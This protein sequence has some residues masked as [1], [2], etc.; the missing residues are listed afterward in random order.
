MK[1]IITKIDE[2]WIRANNPCQAA[3]DWWDKKEKDPIKILDAL[4]KANKLDWAN[5]YIVRIMEYAD[6][7]AYV[8]YAAALVLPDY[9]ARY[10]DDIRPRQA[11]EAARECIANPSEK[12]KTAAARAAYRVPVVYSAANSDTYRAVNSAAYST[13]YSATLK[14]ILT[15]GRTLLTETKTKE[16]KNV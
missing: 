1:S 15:Y 9:E 6:Y 14:T 2:A 16:V 3:L 4:I 10:P 5:W 8:V 11:I 7:V 13:D 12:N